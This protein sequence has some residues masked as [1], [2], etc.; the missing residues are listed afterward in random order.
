MTIVFL[1]VALDIREFKRR[2]I[3]G[4]VRIV[5]DKEEPSGRP[6]NG[7]QTA[8][9]ERR[10][11]SSPRS[12]LAQESCERNAGTRAECDAHSDRT[13]GDGTLRTRQPS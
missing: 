3:F 9:E 12:V 6:H 1:L 11:P 13:C 10:R 8:R 5:G 2:H 4:L 7:Q